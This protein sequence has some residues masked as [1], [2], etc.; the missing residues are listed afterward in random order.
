MALVAGAHPAFATI[1]EDV[2]IRPIATARAG[3]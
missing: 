3:Q 1:R 2:A